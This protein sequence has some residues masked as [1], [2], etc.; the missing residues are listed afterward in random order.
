MSRMENKRRGGVSL[1]MMLCLM[2]LAAT[3]QGC[4]S[5]TSHLLGR[6]KSTKPGAPSNLLASTVLFRV[7][8]NVYPLGYYAALVNIG[9]PPKT[10]DFDFD[11]G[12][13]LSW[14]QCHAPCTSCSVPLSKQY[15]PRYNAIPC[16]NQLCQAINMP[17]RQCTNSNE[18]CHYEL[19]YAD[20]GSSTG[21]VVTDSF[22]LQLV[23]G[24]VI[25]PAIAF[26]CGYHQKIAPVAHPSPTT[27][28]VL[29][30]GKGKSSFIS[31]LR[32][33]NIIRNVIGHCLSR[34]G[35]GFLF[36]GDH[37]V[38]SS[39]TSWTPMIQNSE[40]YYISGP[41]ELLFGRKS[42]GMNVPQ[43]VIDSGSSYTYFSAQIYQTTLNLIKKDLTGKPLK[44]APEDRTL[45]ICW[46]GPKPYKSVDDAKTY[47]KPL[48][49]SFT[50]S[51][52]GQL[53]IPPEHYLIVSKY[54]NVCFGILN[55]TEKGMGNTNV[56]G[57]I[58]LQDKLVIYDN[59]KQLLGWAPAD[60][61]RLPKS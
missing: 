35:G 3:F 47:F 43:L 37:Y 15:R 38:P 9:N 48:T 34:R 59:E 42:A 56:I 40:N 28:G 8:G 2:V 16:S 49:L 4:S 22:P 23:N 45:S 18:Q 60:C 21:V 57:D 39:G 36:L 25:K 55:G 33:Q 12:S 11:T 44:D 10:F 52:K 27:A 7:V 24:T 20:G 19:K 32:A 58:S 54:G 31:Q 46:K 5:E 26:G 61:N 1:A 51:K 29:G 14:V 6:K 17:T 13:D 53:Q 30:L 50:K 41:S